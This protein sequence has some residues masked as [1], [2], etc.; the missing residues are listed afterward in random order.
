VFAAQERV[1]PT[2]LAQHPRGF[3]GGM[4]RDIASGIGPLQAVTGPV[5][6]E[7]FDTLKSPRHV[8]STL[9][10]A[11][12]VVDSDGIWDV[13]FCVTGSVG[14]NERYLMIVWL[15]GT[16]TE[17]ATV[18]DPSNQTDVVN[19]VG[20]GQFNLDTGDVLQLQI[21]SPTGP[22]DFRHEFGSFTATKVGEA[23]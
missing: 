5:P 8:V 21:E 14:L 2:T 18:S 12:I 13:R 19:F 1:L 7:G 22:A 20:C 23:P 15:N 9:A 16:R 17:C 3:F 4:A 10:T 6:V 11:T